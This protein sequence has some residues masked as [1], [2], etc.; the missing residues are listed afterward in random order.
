MLVNVTGCSM[1]EG[2]EGSQRKGGLPEGSCT[3]QV[4][5]V[6]TAQCQQAVKEGVSR[7]GCV[8]ME[9]PGAGPGQG[10]GAGDR[11]GKGVEGEKGIKVAPLQG[12]GLC[13]E[14]GVSHRDGGSVGGGE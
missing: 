3:V 4:M 12:S 8:R 2:L 1:G 13:N 9:S 5:V 7:K 10:V 6:W 11:L 14:V